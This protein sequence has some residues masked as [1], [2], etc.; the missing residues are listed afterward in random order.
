MTDAGVFTGAEKKQ[1]RFDDRCHLEL[2][3]EIQRHGVLSTEWGKRG[4]VWDRV[5]EAMTA[6]IQTKYE[7]VP[8]G[9]AI[10][11]RRCKV[12]KPCRPHILFVCLESLQ[13]ST[14]KF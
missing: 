3:R 14:R 2:L 1:F 8:E 10:D 12:H 4:K 7:S 5:A 11:Q 9:Y 13:L 6:F